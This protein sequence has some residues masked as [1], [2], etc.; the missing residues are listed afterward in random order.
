[1]LPAARFALKGGIRTRKR[2]AT[3]ILA[4]ATVLAGFP[5]TMVAVIGFSGQSI[6]ISDLLI[7]VLV[8]IVA[9][10]SQ[11]LW[12]TPNIYTELEGKSWI[13]V[14]SRP[15]GRTALFLGKYLSAVGFSFAVCFIS[16]SL[17]LAIRT[18][19]PPQSME[20]PFPVFS[21]TVCSHSRLAT[22]FLNKCHCCSEIILLGSKHIYETL[23]NTIT[24]L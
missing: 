10:L 3:F 20:N 21:E 16:I 14:A 17:C 24:C 2:P 9:F 5:P 11:L 12:A 13:F 4:V 6:P 18:Y 22:S 7:M 8:S 1:M 15:R 19:A 23:F